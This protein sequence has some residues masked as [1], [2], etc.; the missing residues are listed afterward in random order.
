MRPVSL[1]MSAFGPYAGET[2]VDMERL[3]ESGLYLITGDTGAGKTTIFDAITFAL[4][5]E[6]SGES[7]SG[8]MMRSQYADA[9]T[10]TFVRLEFLLRG[11]RYCITRSP[12]YER[13]K[14]RGEGTV[15]SKPEAELRCPD[16]RV[17]ASY[18]GVT[19][20]VEALI[21]LTRDQFAQIGMIAQGDFRRILLADTQERREIFRRI[22]HTERYERLEKQL[23]DR[24]N[25]SRRDAEEAERALMQDAPLL[26]VP[27][28]LEPE[29]AKLREEASFIRLEPMMAMARQG[30]TLDGAQQESLEA[31]EQAIAE[32]SAA[33]E[34]RIGQAKALQNARLGLERTEQQIAAQAERTALTQREREAAE[35]LRPQEDALAAQIGLAQAQL[36]E[37][38][39]ADALQAGLAKA[40]KD[41]RAQ[42][43]L[44]V[45]DAQKREALAEAIAKARRLVE[46]LAD[47]RQVQTQAKEGGR[48]AAE[49]ADRLGKLTEQLNAL[50]ESSR[51]ARETRTRFEQAKA[52]KTRAQ[53]A[54]TAAEAAFY[55]AQAGYLAQSLQDG[56]P[57]PVCGSTH[58]PAPAIL[59]EHAP[60][61]ARLN[62]LRKARTR[63]EEAT[64]KALGEAESARSSLETAQ[65]QVALLCEELE[66]AQEK[67][68]VVRAQQ[69]ATAQCEALRQEEARHAKRA[70][71]L[72]RTQQR[73][74]EKE[75]EERRLMDAVLQAQSRAAALQ[76]EAEQKQ[77]QLEQ[78]RGRLTHANL[79]DAQAALEQLQEQKEA[80]H[81]RIQSAQKAEREA[82]E[83]LAKLQASRAAFEEQLADAPPEEPMQ[84]LEAQRDALEERKKQV[85]QQARA[86]HLRMETNGETLARMEAGMQRAKEVR[87]RSRMLASLSMTA[88][89][90]IPGRDKVTL[91]TYV[92]MTCFDRVLRR[93]NRRLSHMTAGQY[94]LRRRR[95]ADNQR[96][97]SGLDVEVIDHINGSVR[98]V[99][100]LSG[101]E[102]F[103]ASLALALG[104]CDEIQE[105]AGGV[106]LDTLFVDEGFG[107]LDSQALTKAI[108]VLAGLTQGHRLVG[109]ISH[110]E[111]LGRRIDRQ[112]VVT[113]DRSGKSH[114][115]VMVP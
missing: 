14:R 20:E 5:G 28:E 25:A 72:E 6:A 69:E 81:Q 75:Q 92:Q 82:A 15:R 88:N 104:L 106:G 39:Q 91:E 90:Q 33:L 114:A 36:K 19:A 77:L 56:Q 23:A 71:D 9:Q 52:E 49:R 89:G 68:L 45:E 51:Q 38:E 46:T 2:T 8:A 97:Q 66:V 105:S 100:T 112:I 34:R 80:L 67:A 50:E 107:S 84:A 43:D 35:V 18:R 22:F 12:E 78:L 29:F 30:L 113:K 48:R 37:Y 21:G 40:L 74:P 73:I 62:A 96:S 26:S 76:S 47:V 115:R 4:Y 99:R 108:S 59:C 42:R 109:I 63:A 85:Q 95:V 17:V 79:R 98:S 102:T 7:R 101:G 103:M 87:E 58:H 24:A 54:Y 61:E 55:G 31:Q 83:A 110:V 3:G 65:R 10:P 27:P 11:K 64:V 16:G 44:A 53:D 70:L 111:E 1:T 32:Q 60:D 57:C 13:P 94:E 41:A 93:A 86:L